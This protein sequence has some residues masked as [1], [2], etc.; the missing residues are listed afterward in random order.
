MAHHLVPALTDA[1][2]DVRASGR[3]PRPAWLPAGVAYL[4]ADLAGPEPLEPLCDGVE[5]IFHLAGAT[6]SLSSQEEMH[7]SNAV[8]T[9]NL[10]RA[11]RGAGVGRLVHMGSTSIYGEEVPLPQ[12]IVE[13]VEPHP[14][15]GYGKAKWLA[16][17][18]VWAGAEDGLPAVVLR[19]V[20][21]FGPGAIKLLAS[22]I[23][24]VAIERYA[25]CPAL[26][27][28]EAPVELRL[29]HVSDV[30]SAAVHVAGHPDALGR[31]FNLVAPWYPSR[32]D[33][34][35]AIGGFLGIAVEST[36]G[37]SCGMDV[38]GRRAT[39]QAMVDAGM[40]PSILF[41]EERFRFLKKANRNNRL[42][43]D[44]IGSTGFRF[45]YGTEAE[46][47]AGIGATIDWYRS[48]R[49]IL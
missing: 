5:V 21:V 29:V 37:P 39:W 2:W 18:A 35:T 17:Q 34:A 14:S 22:A 48:R 9:G 4:P 46:V 32:L 11:A 49:W 6:S 30:V 25:G 23:L 10:V 47:T 24:D 41:T 33:L 27:V 43:V 26:Q 45:S 16:E 1:G 31:A 19:P 20:S 28:E 7:A 40:D 15:R 12:P 44:A 8:A 42:S 36:A 13:T 3:R 38:E